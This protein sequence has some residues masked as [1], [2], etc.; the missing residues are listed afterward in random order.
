M[1]S[2]QRCCHKPALSGVFPRRVP[3]DAEITR[4]GIGCRTCCHALCDR[5]LQ[6]E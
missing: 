6:L 2:F 5:L 4:N 1:G 3:I